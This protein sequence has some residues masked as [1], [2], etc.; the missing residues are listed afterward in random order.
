LTADVG[1]SPIPAGTTVSSHHVFFDPGPG[2]RV[3]GTVA[4]DSYIIGIMTSAT[5]LAAS[6]FLAAPGVNYLGSTARGLEAGD[7]VTIS[8]PNQDSA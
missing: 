6:D 2:L 1:T 5:T 3:T 8:A 7:S 4:F